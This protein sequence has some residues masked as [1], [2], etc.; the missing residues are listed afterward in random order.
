MVS[1]LGA[2]LP[3]ILSILIFTMIVLERDTEGLLVRH[4][5]GDLLEPLNVPVLFTYLRLIT[6]TEAVHSKYLVLT[7]EPA[8]VPAN[9]RPMF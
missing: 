5:K 9:P 6:Q 8:L 7:I 4:L 3:A 2:V 1:T